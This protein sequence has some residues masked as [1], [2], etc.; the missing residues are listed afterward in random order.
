MKSPKSSITMRK[1]ARFFFLF[2][3]LFLEKINIIQVVWKLTKPIRQSSW[4]VNTV[5]YNLF[6]LCYVILVFSFVICVSFVPSITSSQTVLL[7]HLPHLFLGSLDTAAATLPINFIRIIFLFFTTHQ[8]SI[9]HFYAKSVFYF[10]LMA[11]LVLWQPLCFVFNKNFLYLLVSVYIFWSKP[12]DYN[13]KNTHYLGL[14][15]FIKWKKEP[16]WHEAFF[17]YVE[18]R[19]L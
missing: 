17:L 6:N 10:L 4:V 18:M 16:T 5:S 2:A 1:V 13:N 19:Q 7:T 15:T 11:L 3:S 9:E 12:S 14:A 8:L